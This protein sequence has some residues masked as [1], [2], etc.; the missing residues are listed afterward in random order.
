M[1]RSATLARQPAMGEAALANVLFRYLGEPL[2]YSAVPAVQGC[3]AKIN[4]DKPLIL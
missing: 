3:T 2:I 4:G 1:K